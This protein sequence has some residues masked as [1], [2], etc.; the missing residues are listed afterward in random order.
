MDFRLPE[1][2]ELY[3]DELARW[4]DKRPI[5][6][7]FHLDEWR[8]F[9]RRELLGT[10]SGESPVETAVALME[11]TRKGL[12]GPLIDARL[13]GDK[14]DASRELLAAGNVV[15]AAWRPGPGPSAVGW[16]AVSDVTV[17]ASGAVLARGPLPRMV[18]AYLHPHGW[19]TGP[20]PAFPS[21][22]GHARQWLLSGAVLSGLATGSL[23]QATRYVGERV[24]FGRPIGSFQAV[25]FPLAQ[26]KASTEGLRLMVLDAAWRAAA[27][28]DDADIAAA[29]L[30][31]AAD[32]VSRFV[33]DCCHQA[34]G[35][36]GLANESGLNELTWGQRWVRHG[37]D[38]PAARAL[39]N[40][41]RVTDMSPPPS[42]VMQGFA[43]L[44]GVPLTDAD[45]ESSR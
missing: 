7:G 12:P 23:E 17:D 9:A 19:L 28:R 5:R 38:V 25:Q 8:D 24:Q 10:Q 16:G 36:S 33:S 32:R 2:T 4:T 41:R 31:I 20:V 3:R 35:A 44:A 21:E 15:T 26:C 18:T 40:R 27:S 37:M 42:L 39:V 14:D 30:C 34:H 22:E 11:V 6:P 29:L 13:I 45:L 1:E 43:S